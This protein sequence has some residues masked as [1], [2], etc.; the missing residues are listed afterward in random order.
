MTSFLNPTLALA[1]L[2]CVALPILIHIL[3]RR[4]RRPVAFGA[5]RFVLEAYRQQRRRL[6][7]EQILLLACRCLLVLLAALAVGQPL[8]GAL[9]ASAGRG[10]T[11]LA[12]II[13]TSLTTGV[14]AGTTQEFDALKAEAER[15]IRALDPSRGDRVAIIAAGA[16]AQGLIVPATADLS[17][18]LAA[19]ASLTRDDSAF[20]LAGAL[21][22]LRSELSASRR[23]GD[24]AAAAPDRLTLAVLSPWRAGSIGTLTTPGASGL[25]SLGPLA[26]QI[27]IITT[28]PTQRLADNVAITSLEPLRPVM[29]A[30]EERG[31]LPVRVALTRSGPGIEGPGVST[32]RV[33]MQGAEGEARST[34]NWA[35]G[36][37]ALSLVMSVSVAGRQAGAALERGVILNANIDRDALEADNAWRR[38]MVVRDHLEVAIVTPPEVTGA[39]IEALGPGSWLTLAL[40]PTGATRGQRG[41]I[42]VR[43]VDPARELSS[44]GGADQGPGVLRGADAVL[45]ARPDL[46]EG[47]GWRRVAAAL[48][49]GAMVLVMP[50]SDLATH[51]W[52]DA[53][54]DSLGVEWR[55]PREPRDLS[56]PGAISARRP[57]VSGADALSLLSGEIEEL[58]RPVSIRRI[59]A[60]EGVRPGDTLLTLEDGTPLLVRSPRRS[61]DAQP[62]TAAAGTVYF[63]AVP[64]GLSWSDL[65]AKP[66]M[67]PMLQE[68]VRQGVS[69]GN[70][71]AALSAGAVATPGVLPAATREV[72]DLAASRAAD[73]GSSGVAMRRAGVYAARSA[74][75]ATLALLGVNPDAAGSD[76]QVESRERVE[77][78]L[79]GLTGAA[80]GFIDGETSRAQG[81]GGEGSR[82]DAPA[83]STWSLPLLIAAGCVALLELLLARVFSHASATGG[84]GSTRGGSAASSRVKE[85]A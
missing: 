43:L 75:G 47:L 4:R 44:A 9:S 18:A 10:P 70:A 11:T 32:V 12:L 2:A 31:E 16:P 80:P 72:F 3:M 20:D 33:T 30:G 48:G 71:A 25:A 55:L 39:S 49:E 27:D 34:V 78:L 57:V 82:P 59:L 74:Q 38:P 37:D 52:T 24:A 68:L 7:L 63:L 60:P 53:F 73:V 1:G 61:D 23:S 54:T 56:P 69:R 28:P 41:E 22:I 64:P 83:R 77:R 66:L 76:T 15:L 51:A 6:R 79:T 17:Q 58:A 45:V 29:I 35:A 21:S 62:A 5:M 8:L 84:T 13:D 19:V 40:A 26:E 46:I 65:P 85:A 67:L 81:A 36:Q 42:R 14:S 50:P